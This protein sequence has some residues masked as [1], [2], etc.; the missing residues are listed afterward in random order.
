MLRPALKFLCCLAV[1]LGFLFPGIPHLSAASPP[2]ANDLCS[3]AIV[4]PPSGP[5]PY[6]TPIVSDISGATTNGE[7]IPD[8]ASFCVTKVFQGVWYKF[9]PGTGGRYFLSVSFDTAT[10]VPDTAMAIYSSANACTGPLTLLDCN[11]DQSGFGSALDMALT[12][13]T[14]YYVLVWAAYNPAVPPQAALQLRVSKPVAPANDTCAGAFTI[15]AA[16]P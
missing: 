12:G 7:P 14:T 5:F 8:A 6:F 1:I 10:T 3:G 4:I 16:G 13:G 2:P 15:P 9:V 11:D